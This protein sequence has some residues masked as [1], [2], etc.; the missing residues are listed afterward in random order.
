MIKKDP[1]QILL[2]CE[3]TYPFNTGGVSTWANDLC[4]RINNAE[5][6]VYSINSV[7]ENTS[8]YSF[9]NQIKRIIQV[10]MWSPEEPLDCVDYGIDY[11]D[12]LEGKE[13]TTPDV[14]NFKFKE[15]F[16]IFLNEMYAEKRSIS[17]LDKSF[18]EMWSFFQEYDYKTAI[19]S[20]IIWDTFCA[21]IT[22]VLPKDEL[23]RVTL[24]DMTTG[25]RWI[26]RFLIPMAIKVP[27]VDISHVTIA[28]VAIIPAL[29]LKYK[30]GTPILVTEHGVFIRERLLSISTGNYSFFLKKLLINF[31]ECVTKLAYFHATKITTVSNF[32]MPWEA[33]YGAD[34]N[35][36]S[37]IYNG[38]DHRKFKPLPKPKHLENTPTVVAAARIFELKDILTMV[39]TCNEVQ[40]KVPNVQFLVYG[41]KDA[42]P[43]YTREC[44]SL[45]KDLGLGQNFF[46]NGFHNRPHELYAEG[47]ISILTSISEGFPFTVIESMSCGIPV[48]ATDVGGV[49][50][51]LDENCGA[52]CKP[53]DHIQLA[54]QVIILLQDREL[55]L[56]K[57][58]NARKK[59]CEN[60][61]LEKFVQAFEDTYDSLSQKRVRL[62]KLEPSGIIPIQSVG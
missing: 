13:R 21:T 37:V 53:K 55:R 56:L 40:K 44:E 59:V 10:P 12:V 27:K 61:T 22:E 60:F 62:I 46:L 4:S 54:R 29:A 58:K 43:E 45:I 41:N 32:N 52:L 25:L 3:G 23:N 35:K 19:G 2:I 39:R 42:V 15:S 30:Y 49:S 47:D 5:F 38:V 1:K 9:S 14:I 34:I 24:E 33:Y 6:V 48:V 17:V 36:T 11:L 31:S 16:R 7:V 28:G 18:Y 8:K 57:G 20:S 50:E 51:A 26:Y